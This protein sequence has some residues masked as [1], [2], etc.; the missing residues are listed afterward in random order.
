[1]A[2]ASLES[3]VDAVVRDLKSERVDP[4]EGVW[5]VRVEEEIDGH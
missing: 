5:D 2:L 4:I 3:A 1:M